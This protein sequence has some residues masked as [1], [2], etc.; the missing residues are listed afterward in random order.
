M[1]K[2]MIRNRRWL[3]WLLLIGAL[4][5]TVNLSSAFGSAQ[6]SALTTYKIILSR[7][8][9]LG[10]LVQPDW[11]D[12]TATII[13]KVRLPRIILGMF[14]GAALS[15]AG[16]AFQGLMRNPLADP[17]TIGV[18]S[19]AAVGAALVTVLGFTGV[20]LGQMLQPLAAFTGGLLTLLAVY[21]LALIGGRMA[22]E[23]LILAGVVVSAFMSAILSFLIAM[24][25]ESVHQIIFWLMGSLSLRGWE[26]FLYMLPLLLFGLG[27]I[28]ACSKELN[29]FSLGEESAAHM[30]V[31]VEKTKKILLF[32]GAL[33]TGIAVSLS[34][35]IAF[36]GLIIPHLVRMTIGPDH[37]VLIPAS[38][39]VGG[40]Y[41]VWAD[42]IARTVL[43]PVELPVGVVTAFLGVP[44]F[45]YLLR[46]RHM[47]RG[48]GR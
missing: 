20:F 27:L 13:I 17:F 45:A 34:G 8:P 39:V 32:A 7:I 29:L 48:I 25:D 14:V 42:T 31:E 3:F 36:V 37:R 22:V 38:A 44:F 16:A 41:L 9:V 47:N 5:L 43:A 1:D 21:R 40:I 23:T 10:Q 18:S 46:V 35:T 12:T 19:G 28:W 33:V 15:V 6:I 2:G 30:G 24:A 4:V 26:H 11:S